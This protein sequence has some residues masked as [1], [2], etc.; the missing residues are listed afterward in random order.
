MTGRMPAR[1]DGRTRTRPECGTNLGRD[2]HRKVGE[3]VCIDCQRWHARY[4]RDRRQRA[5]RRRE[6]VENSGDKRM[7]ITPGGVA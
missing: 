7:R 5:R 6:L 3:P 4:E 1:E 2:M